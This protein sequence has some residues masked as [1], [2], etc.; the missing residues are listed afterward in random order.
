[1]AENQH[2]LSF[3]QTIIENLP[4]ISNDTNKIVFESSVEAGEV[5]CSKQLSWEPPTRS[6][7]GP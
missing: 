4:S 6:V 2:L 1:M 5:C 3:Q 7:A